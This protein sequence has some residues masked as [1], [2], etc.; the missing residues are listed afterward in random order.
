MR[1]SFITSV[2]S[3]SLLVTCLTGASLSPS[4]VLGTHAGE[5]QLL[6]LGDLMVGRYIGDSMSNHGFD[7]PFTSIK[8]FVS[9][10]DVAVG[11]LEGPLV[12][13]SA[14]TLPTPYPNLPNLAGDLRAAGALSRAGLDVLSLANNHTYDTGLDG[15]QSTVNALQASGIT[16]IGLQNAGSQRPVLREVHGVK[17]AFLAYTTVLNSQLAMP[18]ISYLDPDDPDHR[19]RLTAEVSDARR[20][21][22]VVVLVMH[23]GTEYALQP[24]IEQRE[25]S[26][27]AADA[28]ADLIVGAHPHVA[29]GLDHLPGPNGRTALV[30]YSLGNALFDQQASLETRQGLALMCNVDRNGVKTARLIPIET[31]RGPDGY[32]VQLAGDASGQPTLYRAASSTPPGLQWKAVWDATAQREPGLSLAYRRPF[33]EGATV[34]A[35]IADLGMDSPA[36]IEL[37]DSV[38]TVSTQDASGRTKVG[39]QSEPDWRVTAYTV[40]DANADGRPDLAYSLWKRALISHRPDAGGLAVDLEGGDMLPHIYINSWREG[41]MRPLW[42]GS[43]QHSPVLTVAVAS[44]GKYHKP[45]LATLASNNSL[46]E[47]APGPLR[48]WEWVGGFGYELVS[49][50]P[51]AYSEMWG[52]GDVLMFR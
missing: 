13:T 38:L 40:G 7:A 16:P 35:S 43:P 24:D 32:S 1:N 18:A 26:R 30:A 4:P 23:W 12:D 27:L 15:L 45:V 29:Q 47:R 9:S 19:A 20:N 42:H 46:K 37:R 3:A 8:G 5:A 31:Q 21:S 14:R 44:I 11:N 41:E 10:A 33:S 50:L 34:Q 17:I 36:Y 25:V 52:D 2:L 51:G 49:Q 28:G 22:D 39:W 6:F 48:I